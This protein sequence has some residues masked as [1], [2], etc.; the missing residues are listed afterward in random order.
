MIN[1]FWFLVVLRFSRFQP[2]DSRIQR[3]QFHCMGYRRTREGKLHFNSLHAY[4]HIFLFLCLSRLDLSGS[5]DSQIVETLFPERAGAHLCS[6]Q[7]R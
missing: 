4:K 1:L 6:G 3:H 5:T 7:Q 2:R